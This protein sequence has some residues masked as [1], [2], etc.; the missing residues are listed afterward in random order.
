MQAVK[1][2]KGI[3][4]L[5]FKVEVAQHVGSDM[6]KLFIHRNKIFRAKQNI[7]H[8]DLVIDRTYRL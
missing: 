8:N 4:Q 6:L 3:K 5:I 7:Y 1:R 2:R